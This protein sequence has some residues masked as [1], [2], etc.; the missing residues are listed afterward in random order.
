MR[1]PLRRARRSLRGHAKWRNES[2]HHLRRSHISLFRHLSLL[3]GDTMRKSAFLFCLLV[4]MV[5]SS[6]HAQTVATFGEKSVGSTNCKN[7]GSALDFDAIAQCTSTT[8]TTGTM[9]K[10]PV[11]VGAVTT[12]PYASTAC[13][14]TKAGMI[15]YTATSGFMGCNGTS[16]IV[17]RGPG[18]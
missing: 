3:H 17:M 2:P 6:S 13:D 8:S 16:W 15:Q 10:A 9:Q 7:S 5:A 1:H 11:F 4:L 14:S 12:P 18:S